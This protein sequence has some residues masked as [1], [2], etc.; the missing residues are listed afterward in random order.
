M[1]Y[2]NV[3]RTHLKEVDVTQNWEPMTLQ[4]SHKLLY[5]VVY[6]VKGPM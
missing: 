4:K 3:H 2:R 6:H 5:T 1:I